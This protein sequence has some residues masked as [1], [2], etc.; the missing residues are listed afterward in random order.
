MDKSSFAR[1]ADAALDELVARLDALDLPEV[2]VE[3]ADGK[4]VIEIEGGSPLIVSRQAATRQL[5]LAEPRGGWHFDQRGEVWVCDKRGI[6][7]SAA[8]SEELSRLLAR[9]VAL[10]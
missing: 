1:D 10:E 3:L 5:W 4:L 7:L 2:D 8:L 6:T 9:P